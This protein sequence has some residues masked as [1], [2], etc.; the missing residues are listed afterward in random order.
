MIE[1]MIIAGM[2]V[3]RLNFSHGEHDDIRKT[4]ETIRSLSEKY[5]Y[6]VSII[7]DIQG[8]KIRTGK[9][10]EPFRVNPSDIIR[11]T[12]DDV[13]GNCDLIQ[14]RYQSMLE[15]L[16]VGDLIFINDGIIR[17]LVTKK[18][19]RS[20]VCLV[21]SG[22]LISDNKGCNILSNDR[23]S[24]NAITSKDEK[25]LKLIAELDPEWVAASFIG[26][27][28]DVVKVR[29]MLAYFG[30]ENI[31]I[32]SKIERQVALENIDNIIEVTDSIMIARGDLG[33]EIPL[34]D[35]PTAQKMIC[36]K[37]NVAGKP[38]IVA[39]QMLE[40]MISCIRP[41]RAEATD[42]Y[43]A[44]LDGAD[45]VM[46]S[47]ESAI[48]KYPIDAI[49]VMDKIV[50]QAEKH[51]IRPDVTT[52]M[53]SHLGM[54]ETVGLAAYIITSNFEELNWT[55]KIILIADCPSGYIARMISKFRPKVNIIGVSS[56]KRTALE[57]NLLF[58]VRS[59]WA[60][61]LADYNSL[62]ALN[63]AM[64]EQCIKLNLLQIKD[65]VLCIN[66]SLLFGKNAG[67]VSAIYDLSKMRPLI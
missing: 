65:H 37:C 14:I 26:Y 52:F 54:T 64:I 19:E 18:E 27:P 6:Q 11:V 39:T 23:I 9:M 41:T 21:E 12:P 24:L 43:N 62:E 38:V 22:G 25:D 55:G 28:Q 60:S 4:F 63:T 5:N 10:K 7:C 36:R 51:Y 13:I 3:V 57:L 34:W 59:I 40:S 66:H 2:D 16:E 8:P 56:D 53:G 32:I 49:S 58:G 45:A 33:V 50:D 46:L 30:N 35:V 67:T 48:G 47:G 20:L 29:N 44:V 1:K 61:K 31:K 42:V 17:L 15:E